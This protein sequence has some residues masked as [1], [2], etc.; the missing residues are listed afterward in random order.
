MVQSKRLIK[1][2]GKIKPKLGQEYEGEIIYPYIPNQELIDAVNFAITLKRP[3]LLEG[4]PG[5]GKSQLARAVAFDLRLPYKY[6]CAKST[7][8]IDDLLYKF[9]TIGRLRDAQ[10]AAFTDDPAEQAKIKNPR[11]YITLGPLGEAFHS[12]GQN[13]QRKSKLKRTVLLIDE[14]DKADTD[15]P[16]DLLEVL[17]NKQFPIK[18]LHN[19]KISP[20]DTDYIPDII[21]ADPDNMPIIIIASNSEK[22]LSNAFL[23]RCLYYYVELPD[24]KRLKE[25]INARFPGYDKKILDQALEIF[26]KLRKTMEAN[27]EERETTKII[28]TSEWIDWCELIQNYTPQFNRELKKNTLPFAQVLLKNQKDRQLYSDMENINNINDQPQG[29]LD[30]D[31]FDDEE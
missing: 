13:N 17:E 25:I 1:Y 21:K 14:I 16:N 3:L 27:Q 9:D 20:E 10:L 7:S 22:K 23:R 19:Q 30:D 11:T 5:G 26:M 15:F 8:K 24:N 28:S 6:Y 4:E 29:R 18:E 2:T 12:S 31:N